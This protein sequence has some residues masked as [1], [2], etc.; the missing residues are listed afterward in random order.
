MNPV[1]HWFDILAAGLG[2][3][4][5][6]ACS[7]PVPKFR[8]QRSDFPKEAYVG[9]PEDK[10]FERIGVVRARADYLSLDPENPASNPQVLCRNYYNRAVQDL[11]KFAH[12]KKADAVIEVKS[13]VFLLDGKSELHDTAECADDGAEG[14]ALVQ[15]VAVK[16]IKDP[17]VEKSKTN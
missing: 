17:E 16:W 9:V 15:G 10:K 2:L 8:Y 14:Q 6:C 3:A 5:V 1:R 11:V 12:D 13:V 7:T 4:L